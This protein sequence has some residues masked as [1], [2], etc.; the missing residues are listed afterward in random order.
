MTGTLSSSG[1]FGGMLDHIEVSGTTDTSDFHLSGSGHSRRLSTEFHA[2]VDTTNGDTFLQ[3]VV[4]QFDRTT[5][6]SAGRV[7]GDNGKLASLDL[8][9][10]DARIEDLLN[11]FIEAKRAPMTG[12]VN[13]GAHVEIPPGDE[14]FVNK[15]KLH[16]DFGLEGGKFTNPKTQGSINKLSASAQ[17][18]E[19]HDSREEGQIALSNLKGHVT[20]TDGIA[21][22]TNLSFNIPGAFARL[23]GTYS[24]I[25]YTVDVHGTLVTKGKL[26][27]ATS[28]M[29]SVLV[30]A[31][32]PLLKK[33]SGTRIIPFKITGKYQ[34]TMVSLDI[35]ANN[36]GRIPHSEVGP[37]IK[38]D[39]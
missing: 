1:N 20:V 11:L 16:G 18:A 6:V 7:A 3:N 10:T 37:L 12:T 36:R 33:R 5:I 19:K 21:T 27:A 39:R 9:A 32:A 14:Q 29:K 8:F 22:L 24:L 2:A 4:G 13:F 25:D 15:L 35:A 30:K 28:G 26:S 31:I 17:K 38:V 23:N 34:H